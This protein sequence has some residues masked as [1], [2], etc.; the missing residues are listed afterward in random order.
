M[1][2]TLL[3]SLHRLIAGSRG[4]SSGGLFRK[5]VVFSCF[6]TI[7]PIVFFI[8]RILPAQQSIF[9]S[10]LE[11]QIR[12][13]AA[14]IDETSVSAII[15]EDYTPV[16]ELCQK[17]LYESPNLEY[18]VL[19]RKET[20]FSLVT[21]QDGWRQTTL[22]GS[23]TDVPEDRENDLIVRANPWAEGEILHLSYPIDYADWTWG[24]VHLGLSSEQFNLQIAAIRRRILTIAL[25]SIIIGMVGSFFFSSRLTRP[26]RSLNSSIQSLASGNLRARAEISTGDEVQQLADAFNSMAESL[27][28]S[29]RALTTAKNFNENIIRSSISMLIVIS[30]E[31]YITFV[32]RSV[33]QLLGY[34]QDEIVGLPLD[35]ILVEPVHPDDSQTPTTMAILTSRNA[36]HCLERTFRSKDGST[37]PVLLSGSAMQIDGQVEALVCSALD[38][39]E[40]KHAEIELEQLHRK[41]VDASHLAGMAEVANNVLHN[42]G[43]VLKQRERLRRLSE[44]KGEWIPHPLS[45]ARRVAHQGSSGRLGRLHC[46]RSQGTQTASL[47]GISRG[48]FR[49]G[50]AE[51][52]P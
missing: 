28:Q 31:G 42:V 48:A 38:I 11:E 39:T 2:P 3:K 19:T 8:S 22:S 15:A 30:P 9:M 37:I 16:I 4:G 34:A 20:G 14:S 25:L 29:Q 27:E 51:R 24:W 21:R 33:V 43:N 46:K 47:H 41:I 7:V 50:A 44:G 10:N 35:R 5:T 26:I 32:N 13:L 1:T 45:V 6:I 36:I 49:S 40:R 17:V 52:L 18:V 23:W 12:S